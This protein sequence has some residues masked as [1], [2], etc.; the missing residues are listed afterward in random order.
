MEHHILE[1]EKCGASFLTGP[2]YNFVLM[3]A[4]Y[5]RKGKVSSRRHLSGFTEEKHLST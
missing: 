5:I 2:S 1:W 4:N 3:I